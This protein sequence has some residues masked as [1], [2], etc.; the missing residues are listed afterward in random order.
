MKTIAA[1]D[2]ATCTG[3]AVRKDSGRIESG[4]VDL[5]PGGKETRPGARWAN[6]RR[7]LVDLKQSNPDLQAIYFEV[8]RR[9]VSTQSAH[10]YG[11]LKGLLELFAFNHCIELHAVGVGTWKKKFTGSGAADKKQVIALCRDLGFRPADD[12]E[13]DALGILLVAIDQCP[14]LAPSLPPRKTRVKPA[15]VPAGANPF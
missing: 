11:A 3:F 9:H 6:F 12:N 10:C 15:P 2:L 14:V 1:L 8:V 4:T 5:R 7:F 13:A